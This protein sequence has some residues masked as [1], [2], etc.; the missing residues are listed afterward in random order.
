MAKLLATMKADD[1]RVT[2]AGFYD[3]VTPLT[4]VEQAALTAIPDIED[5][6]ATTFAIAAPEQSDTRLETKLN[7]P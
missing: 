5:N 2:I 4:D 6:L 1:G 3:Q 7:W